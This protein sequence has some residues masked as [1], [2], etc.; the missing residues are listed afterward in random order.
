MRTAVTKIDAALNLAD[1]AIPRR[2]R[3][4]PLTHSRRDRYAVNGMICA[5]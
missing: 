5:A 3:A 1:Q 4:G 2:R